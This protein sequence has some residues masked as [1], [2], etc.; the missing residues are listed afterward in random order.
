MFW[1]RNGPC[2][3]AS[4][5]PPDTLR[6]THYWPLTYTSFWLE[7]KLWG[8]NPAGYHLVNVLVHLANTLLVWRLLKRLALP[9]AWLIAAVFAIHPVRVEPVLWIISR[10][11]LL[12]T[13]CYLG[14]ALLYMDAVKTGRPWP[15]GGSVLCYGLGLLAKSSIL[16]LPAGLL[17]W[18][19]WN[20]GRIKASDLGRLLPFVGLGLLSLG[21]VT[22]HMAREPA[23]FNYSFLE[24]CLL[25]ARSLWFYISKTVWPTN[26]AVIYPRWETGLGNGVA[27]LCLLGLLGVGVSLWLARWRIGR[28]PLAGLLFFAVTLLPTLGFVDF[29]YLSASFV[30]DRYQYLAGLGIIALLIATA[31]WLARRLPGLLRQGSKFAAALLLAGLAAVS[32]QQMGIYSNE[33]TFWGH[34]AQANPAARGVSGILAQLLI[35]EGRPE[36]AVAV[37]RRF[38]QVRPNDPGAHYTEAR[39]LLT[40]G[41]LAEAGDVYGRALDLNPDHVASLNDLA[42]LH[43]AQKRYGE[44]VGI[45]RRLVGINPNDA[46][47][48]TNLG[49]AL[50]H[51]GFAAEAA[52][53]LERALQLNPESADA[54][55]SLN[56][57]RAAMAVSQPA[58]EP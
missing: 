58:A 53:H 41:R 31:A 25:A 49:V 57:V 54:R 50:Y 33:L 42:R 51:A 12:S 17:V 32:W 28:G 36:D 21:E 18:H 3:A 55:N 48:R 5:L 24:R 13:T 11:D 30:A 46:R 47:H 29:T 37:A 20:R 35:S 43:L 45:Y 40:L 26:L 2:W 19:W 10:K 27:W 14:A 38:S 44:A 52:S 22:Y 15:Y 4:G 56:V 8:L 7:H 23:S 6:E 9:A 39:T 1:C 16:T 34:I